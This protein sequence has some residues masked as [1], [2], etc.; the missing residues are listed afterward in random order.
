MSKN[1]LTDKTHEDLRKEVMD[2]Q[3]CDKLKGFA[4]IYIRPPV[5]CV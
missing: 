2:W 1:E 5:C 4:N 3:D